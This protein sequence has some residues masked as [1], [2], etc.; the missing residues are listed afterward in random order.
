MHNIL[1]PN[2]FLFKVSST[3]RI[4]PAVTTAE[5]LENN[6][7][8]QVRFPAEICVYHWNRSVSQKKYYKHIFRTA[9][10]PR[11]TYSQE[12]LFVGTAP[13]G[14][15]R[16]GLQR[17]QSYKQWV[18][19][20]KLQSSSCTWYNYQRWYTNHQVTSYKLISGR[21]ALIT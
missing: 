17:F 21:L 5:Y 3:A 18:F 4:F 14:C 12:H 7:W 15:F 11:I 1:K 6:S 10:I 13:N 19:L 16:K 9:L 2:S 8:E 20:Q